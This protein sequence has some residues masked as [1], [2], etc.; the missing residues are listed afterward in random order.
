[1]TSLDKNTREKKKKK[2]KKTKT[3]TKNN[4]EEGEKPNGC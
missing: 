4:C 1:M 3:K 2:K